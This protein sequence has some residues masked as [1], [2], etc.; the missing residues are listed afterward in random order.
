MIGK[1]IWVSTCDFG[2]CR[3]TE[4]RRFGE[5]VRLTTY[6]IPLVP[7]VTVAWVLL[8]FDKRKSHVLA[9]YSRLQV[10]IRIVIAPTI[11]PL[12]YK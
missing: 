11:R 1:C 10:F 9:A 8:K 3:I 12:A 2:A 4:Q 5:P 6:F 7:L